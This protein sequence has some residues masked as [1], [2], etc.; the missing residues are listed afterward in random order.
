LKDLAYRPAC[1]VYVDK[2]TH[3][4]TDCPEAFRDCSQSVQ[5]NVK[6]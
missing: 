5:A 6:T 1:I 3:T 2:Y 4:D